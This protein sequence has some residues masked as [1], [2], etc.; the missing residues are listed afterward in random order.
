[1]LYLL[2][3]FADGIEKSNRFDFVCFVFEFVQ[4]AEFRYGLT[5]YWHGHGYL[6]PRKQICGVCGFTAVE[7]EAF[8]HS[9]KTL[10]TLV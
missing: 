10:G 7:L 3:R 1:M 6:K 4:F 5:K 9:G 8:L 2:K